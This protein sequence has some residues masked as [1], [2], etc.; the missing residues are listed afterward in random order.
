MFLLGTWLITFVANPIKLGWFFWHPILQSLSIAA[1]TYGEC[2]H[3]GALRSLTELA[4][5][6]RDASAYLAA[7]NEGSGALPPS[8]RHA[9]GRV[10]GNPDG[11][12]GYLVE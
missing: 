3:G 8:D 9:L 7:Q 1:F 6:N 11:Y 2:H 5:R 12:I 4:T 10:P